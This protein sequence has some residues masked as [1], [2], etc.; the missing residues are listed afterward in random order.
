MNPTVQRTHTPLFNFWKRN[1]TFQK[2]FANIVK[3]KDDEI[4]M[5]DSSVVLYHFHQQ[6]LT[7]TIDFRLQP[8]E[9]EEERCERVKLAVKQ[10]TRFTHRFFAFVN[11]LYLLYDPSTP[12][13]RYS[14]KIDKLL[15]TKL[16]VARQAE[17]MLHLT[18][19]M[20]RMDLRDCYHNCNGSVR[21]HAMN[22]D[23]MRKLLNM[24][25]FPNLSLFFIYGLPN[26]VHPLY[27]QL[28][29]NSYTLRFQPQGVIPDIVT[30]Q[31]ILVNMQ[32]LV[33]SMTDYSS[34]YSNLARFIEL[35]D[36][37]FEDARQ[38]KVI[39]KIEQMIRSTVSP[40]GF[41]PGTFRFIIVLP[42]FP[43]IVQNINMMGFPNRGT[44]A[45]IHALF[46]E[47]RRL[48]RK[49]KIPFEIQVML[50]RNIERGFPIV[51][52]KVYSLSVAK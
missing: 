22:V 9:S 1:K 30:A 12:V 40:A 43:K 23:Y 50:H 26:M 28:S 24:V 11:S 29:Y 16:Q 46:R 13:L 48:Y 44:K 37:L 51:Y 19:D 3:F 7:S 27:D 31:N 34:Y 21:Y 4:N 38:S 25:K 14:K 6:L 47:R 8:G 39:A 20:H 41:G 36:R 18:D 32:E 42:I 45:E 5:S 17:E 15:Q 35:R 33:C 10:L 2:S 52:Q 49:W